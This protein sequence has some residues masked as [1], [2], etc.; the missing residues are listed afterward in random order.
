MSVCVLCGVFTDHEMPVGF[1]EIKGKTLR[2]RRA[3]RQGCRGPVVPRRIDPKDLRPESSL[4]VLEI[5]RG[6]GV[7]KNLPKGV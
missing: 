3:W 4:R 1:G 7:F 2:E 6:I 5:S